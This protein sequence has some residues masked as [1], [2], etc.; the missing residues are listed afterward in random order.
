[1]LFFAS[2]PFCFVEERVSGSE[3]SSVSQPWSKA[4]AIYTV[5]HYIDI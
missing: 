5:T 1:M 4:L 3:Q 2:K